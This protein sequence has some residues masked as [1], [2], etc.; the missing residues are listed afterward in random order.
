MFEE[1]EQC[2]FQK[3]K[4]VVLN[5][6]RVEGKPCI[7]IESKSLELTIYLYSCYDEHEA[8]RSCNTDVYLSTIITHEF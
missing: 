5:E 1:H 3:E 2:L 4:N 6:N 7:N 8:P